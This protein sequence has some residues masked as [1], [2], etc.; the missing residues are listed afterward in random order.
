M[1]VSDWYFPGISILYTLRSDSD[2]RESEEIGKLDRVRE[3][4]R[5]RFSA[6]W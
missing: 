4:E 2:K 6:C 1:G 3:R 5:R